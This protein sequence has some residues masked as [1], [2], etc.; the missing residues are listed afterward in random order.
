MEEWANVLTSNF[1]VACKLP[2]GGGF[3]AG[4]LLPRV[5]LVPVVQIIGFKVSREDV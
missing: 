5:Q 4:T 2:E 3:K 1:D